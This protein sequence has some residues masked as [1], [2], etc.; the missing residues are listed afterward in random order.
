MQ[1]IEQD[2]TIVHEGL[3]YTSGGA[4]VTPDRIVAYLGKDGVLTDWH[5]ATIGQYRIKSTW[6]TPHSG[7]SD[8]MHQCYARVDGV[9]YTGRSAGVG[10]VF[11][12]RRV[13]TRA[14]V[15]AF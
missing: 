15:A 5:G 7:L 10:M 4:C 13:S 8:S 14:R 1:Y 12:G 3:T 11:T 9:T 2:C 6:R